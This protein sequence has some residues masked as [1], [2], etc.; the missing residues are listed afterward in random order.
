MEWFT[1]EQWSPYAVGVGIGILSWITFLISDKPIGASTAYAR[2]SGMIEKLFRGKKTEENPYYQKFAPI[3][4]WEWML[5][6]G[7]IFGALISSIISNDF[8]WQWIPSVWSSSFGDELWIRLVVGGAG[9]IL[10]GFG[11]RWA[12]GCTSGHGISGTMQMAVSSW[13]SAICFFVG[14]IILAQLLFKV[15]A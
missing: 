1:L 7:M 5:V 8:S 11:S 2:T 12:D 9:G 15:M 10:L 13:I 14:G 3:I 6:V 4:D